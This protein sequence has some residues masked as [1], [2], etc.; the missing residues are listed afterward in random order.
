MV[1]RSTLHFLFYFLVCKQGYNGPNCAFHCR[2][3]SYGMDC[4]SECYCEESECN[5][6][7]GCN[8]ISEL[9]YYYHHQKKKGNS[10]EY[11][12]KTFPLGSTVFACN[13]NVYNVHTCQQNIHSDLIISIMAVN[14]FM[15]NSKFYY[16]QPIYYM[17]Y[18]KKK[19]MNTRKTRNNI[20]MKIIDA[21]FF[22][23]FR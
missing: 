2:Y 20:E 23:Q 7:A 18:R 10:K 1:D 22:V 8:N 12:F 16:K 15:Y 13:H 21:M 9:Y 6:I 14:L 4:Q 17:P 3:P 11:R 5:H 19:Y